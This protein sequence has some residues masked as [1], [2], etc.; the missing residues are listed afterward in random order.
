LESINFISPIDFIAT[1]SKLQI[2]TPNRKWPKLQISKMISVIKFSTQ[3]YR[4]CK[5]LCKI[6]QPAELV[7]SDY[8]I[9]IFTRVDITS[10]Y[11]Q[12]A[13]ICDILFDIKG[14]H[15]RGFWEYYCNVFAA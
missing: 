12:L 6:D 8:D 2:P 3:K 13:A 10:T 11:L 1:L 15:R 5:H 4:Y 14:F 9:R 7:I